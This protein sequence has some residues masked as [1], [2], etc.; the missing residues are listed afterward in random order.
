MA[1]MMALLLTGCAHSI[2]I[3][4]D[5]AKLNNE[6]NRTHRIPL[7][8]GY[9]I[10][11]EISSIE[12]VTQGGGGDNVS[13]FPYRDMD[14]GYRKILS[15]IFTGVVKLDSIAN[16]PNT[17]QDHIDYIFIPDIVTV[18]GS[19]GFFTW[20]PTNF[21]VDLT[22]NVRDTNGKMITNA[23]VVGMGSAATGELFTEHGLAGKRAMEDALL[24][25]QAALTEL[26]YSNTTLPVN[27]A[28]QPSSSPASKANER[29]TY[30]KELKDKGLLSKD[31]YEAKRKEILKDL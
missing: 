20:P 2:D 10:P 27:S 30:I 24:K 21:T 4:P 17:N 1:I 12:T 7:K 15:N 13:Y 3:A 18:S 8:V 19:T 25:M 26:K 23:R 31:E 28:T 11:L 6:A 16:L 5:V 14:Y 9:Y 29:M 22:S